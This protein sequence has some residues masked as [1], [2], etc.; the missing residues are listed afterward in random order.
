M[1]ISTTDP[2]TMNDVTDPENHPYLIEGEGPSAIKIYFESE[3][4]KQEYLDI[5]TEHSGADFSTD[6]DN[7]QSMAGDPP[8]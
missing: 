4:T 2:I 3:Q 5:A 7:P 6:P 8:R 1:M